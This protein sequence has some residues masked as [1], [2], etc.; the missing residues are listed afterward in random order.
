M[1]RILTVGNIN[2]ETT[3]RVSGFPVQ[4]QSA[5]FVPFGVENNVSG[6]GYNLA[7]ALSVLGS[8]VVLAGIV[9]RDRAAATVRAQL[10]DDTLDD[11]Y[12]I[13]QVEKTAL[14]V[15]MYDETGRRAVFVDVKDL[16]DQSYPSDLFSEALGGVDAVLFTQVA[17]CRPLLAGARAAG[18]LVAADLQLI[19]DLDDDYKRP[20]LEEAAVVFMSDE[21]L[22]EAPEDWARHLMERYPGVDVVG[23]GLGSAGAL[24]A[25]RE[26]GLILRVP[27]VM[28]RPIVS[29]SGAGDALFAAFMHYYSD[30]GDPE[31]AMRR[32]VVFAGYKIGEAGSS[33]GFLDVA[34][35]EDV[36]GLHSPD[37]S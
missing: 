8:E 5:L 15:V 37:N 19:E 2:L 29:T 24:L 36:H 21:Q 35:L 31:G 23:I 33:R 22:P 32:A 17:Y 25:V 11:H 1:S 14:S 3:L 16:M 20:Y 26:S 7:R 18:K 27:A 9:G 28:P 30:T 13:G 6:V 4:Y 10:R 12:V 34:G